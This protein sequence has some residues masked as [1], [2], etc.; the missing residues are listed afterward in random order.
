MQCH[1]LAYLRLVKHLPDFK[2]VSV[3]NKLFISLNYLSI[4]TD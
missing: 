2:Q 1:S 4:R 3:K